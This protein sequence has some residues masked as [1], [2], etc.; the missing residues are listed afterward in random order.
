MLD[1]SQ[2]V[3]R[4]VRKF[5]LQQAFIYYYLPKSLGLRCSVTSKS[6][7]FSDSGCAE[8]KNRSILML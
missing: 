1:K 6:Y 3:E 7:N 8:N 5:H 2:M 4:F